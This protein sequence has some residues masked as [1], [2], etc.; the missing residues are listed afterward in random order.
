MRHV[1]FHCLVRDGGYPS[2]QFFENYTAKQEESFKD[3]WRTAKVKLLRAYGGCLGA[4]RRRRARQAAKS[5]GELQA[6]VD[7]EVPE[8]GNPAGVI[9]RHPVLNT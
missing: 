5:F 7:P 3:S 6:S 8:W 1:T 4:K 9:P 2:E